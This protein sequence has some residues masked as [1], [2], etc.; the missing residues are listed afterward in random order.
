MPQH[1]AAP[2]AGIAATLDNTLVR[3][4]ATLVVPLGPREVLAFR[5]YREELLRWAA[6]MNLTGLETAEQIVRQGFLDSLACLPLMPADAKHALDVGSGA[7][8][9]AIPLAIVRPH[10]HFTLV[11]AS[12]KK[13]TFLR[14]V[15]RQLELTNVRVIPSRVE[16]LRNDPTLLGA[17]DA[18]L[19]RAVAPLAAVGELTRPFLRPGGVFLAQVGA[20]E[21]S[22]LALNRLSRAGF[23]I[24]GTLEV[25]AEFGKAGRRIVAL[26]KNADRSRP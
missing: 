1:D 11:D 13:V 2:G 14:H 19:A 3:G 15:A 18:A 9:P 5:T 20:G 26:R 24:A 16:S 8:F 21:P 12:R 6:R 10:V 25:P 22:G 17:F 23:E 4:A 7:G